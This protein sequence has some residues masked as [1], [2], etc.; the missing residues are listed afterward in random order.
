MAARPRVGLV[1]GAGGPVGRAFQLA[2]LTALERERGFDLTHAS[3]I[4]GTSAG[5]IVAAVTA[6]GVT[7]GEQLAHVRGRT[8]G[9]LAGPSSVPHSTAPGTPQL[10]LRRGP[11]T[12][13][14]RGLGERLRRRPRPAATVLAA[15]LPTG[16]VGM[17][18][19]ASWIDG[20]V[21]GRWPAGLRVCAVELPGLDRV[22]WGEDPARDPSPGVAVAASCA[23]P[24]FLAPVEHAGRRFVDGGLHSPTN[25]DVLLS[26][27]CTTAVVISPMS[28]SGL[29]GFGRPDRPL[30]SLWHRRLRQ[31]LRSL[32][33]AGVRTVVIE[34]DAREYR[35]LPPN[36]LDDTRIQP[37]A[38]FLFRSLVQRLRV[39]DLDPEHVLERPV[40]NAR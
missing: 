31:E 19:H 30:R 9:R 14:V 11:P 38:G 27:G 16:R 32:E 10:A 29:H 40:P 28:T 2:A 17:L 35:I 39:G 37:I 36:L 20:L 8:G 18:D 6:A 12:V 5:A 26:R 24:G 1:L 34:P 15:L 4:V 7:A 33:A 25:A 22:V 13:P 21:D 23:I 3:V